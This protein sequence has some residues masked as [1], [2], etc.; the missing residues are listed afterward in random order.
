MRLLSLLTVVLSL[1]AP[2]P[3]VPALPDG[4]E[5]RV[6]REELR[7][8]VSSGTVRDGVL[9]LSPRPPAGERVQLWLA[10]PGKGSGTELK[11]FPGEVVSSGQDINV[12]VEPK[13]PVSFRDVL[14]KVYGVRLEMRS[15]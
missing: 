10:M 9:V 4:S 6:L 1:A 13:K 15:R 3:G 5:V 11:Q 14:D 7:S 12:F 8:I 2:L